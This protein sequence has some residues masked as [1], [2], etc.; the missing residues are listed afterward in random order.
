MY[1]PLTCRIARQ[2]LQIMAPC[3]APQIARDA[4]GSLTA[5]HGI[6]SDDRVEK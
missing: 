4:E 5:P 1:L 6:Q 2:A 3:E